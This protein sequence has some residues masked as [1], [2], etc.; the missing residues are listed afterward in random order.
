MRTKSLSLCLFLIFVIAITDANHP[1]R[2]TLKPLC[3]SSN[4]YFY[5]PACVKAAEAKRL[6]QRLFRTRLVIISKTI[7]G[8]DPAVLK[9]MTSA[10]GT[11]MI[12]K[13]DFATNDWQ[14]PWSWN[15]VN[16]SMWQVW[17]TEDSTGR[18]VRLLNL[19]EE[20]DM[21]TGNFIVA[22]NDTTLATFVCE[23]KAV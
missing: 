17:V 19:K 21:I 3:G 5:M 16:C 9:S 22:H 7:V 2:L 8:L 15:G 6:C 4:C 14:K 11:T 13:F 18:P 10:I 20:L 1:D 12:S 23:G